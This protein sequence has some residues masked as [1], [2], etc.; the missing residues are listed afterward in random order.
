MALTTKLTVVSTSKDGKTITV[1]DTTGL[2]DATTNPGGYGAPNPSI[3]G[4]AKIE[5][6]VESFGSTTLTHKTEITETTSPDIATT[7]GGADTP[8]IPGLFGENTP[9][10]RFE[11]G[12]LQ[13]SMI[14]LLSSRAMTGTAGTKE[15]AANALI[16]LGTGLFLNGVYYYIDQTKVNTTS[17][18]YLTTPLLSNVTAGQPFYLATTYAF[19]NAGAKCCI[20]TQTGRLVEDSC[21]TEQEELLFRLFNYTLAAETAFS[22]KNYSKADDL[23]ERVKEICNNLKCDC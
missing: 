9:T 13:V 11:D 16:T 1:K 18:V 14:T 10:A 2:Y 21:S 12:V 19:S 20:A 15:V 5:F 23:A 4:L 22:L 7:A 3:P 8:L 17:L 6:Y